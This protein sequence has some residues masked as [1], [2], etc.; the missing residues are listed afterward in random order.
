MEP[1]DT[2]VDELR[3]KLVELFETHRETP[4]AAFD[5]ST[6]LD[7]LLAKPA[8]RGAI[9]NSVTGLG[10]L[11]RFIRDVELDQGI[12]LSDDELER[13]WSSF[14]LAKRVRHKRKNPGAGL[15]F[16]A[17]RLAKEQ[18]AFMQ[19]ALW[20]NLI[21]IVAVVTLAGVIGS[22]LFGLFGAVLV[23]AL[24]VMLLRTRS[25]NVAHLREL[26]GLLEARL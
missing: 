12:C 1:A 6:F 9:R 8:G 16:V 15:R 19:G 11:H 14:E 26:K 24:N 13:D 22:K 17:E 10:R 20:L 18:S 7:Y 5:D 25:R 2:D 4:G 23:I 3:A 21:V